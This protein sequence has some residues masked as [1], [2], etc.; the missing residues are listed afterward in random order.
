MKVRIGRPSGV[1]GLQGGGKDSALI[2]IGVLVPIDGNIDNGGRET[3]LISEKNHREVGAPESGLD[4]VYTSSG[5]IVGS[6]RNSV[7]NI[8]HWKN[9]GEGGTVGGAAAGSRGICK[10]DWI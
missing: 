9:T 2:R 8:L 7:G 1:N 5:V 4:V 6:D 3:H 10:G